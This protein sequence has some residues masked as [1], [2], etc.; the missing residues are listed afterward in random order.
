MINATFTS[1]PNLIL[2]KINQSID[3]MSVDGEK[4]VLSETKSGLPLITNVPESIYSL[5]Y[6]REYIPPQDNANLNMKIAE[7]QH[8]TDQLQSNDARQIFPNESDS[9]VFRLNQCYANSLRFIRFLQKDKLILKKTKIEIVFGYI[10]NFIFKGTL[11]GDIVTAQ[12]RI[13]IHDWHVWN[14]YDNLLVDLSQFNHGN[15][16]AID[17][18]I[19]W[20]VASYHVFY[21][22]PPNTKYSGRKFTEVN[23]FKSEMKKHLNF[24]E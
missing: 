19:L 8:Y 5:K 3:S 14:Y 16:F 6:Q 13:A 24:K 2:E 17:A 4:Y 10:E 23:K 11:I 7:I 12:E 21:K 15:R 1:D 18:N 9:Q 20:G 22:I